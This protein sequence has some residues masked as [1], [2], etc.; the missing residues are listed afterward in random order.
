MCLFKV[1]PDCREQ[2]VGQLRW[3]GEVQVPELNSS[4]FIISGQMVKNRENRL[5]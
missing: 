1:K 2:E 4:L 5:V 3:T